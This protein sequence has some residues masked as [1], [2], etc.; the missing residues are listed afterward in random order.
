M[1]LHLPPG[2]HVNS[3]DLADNL[4]YILLIL[5]RIWCSLIGHAIHGEGIPLPSVPN[6][7]SALQ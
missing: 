1:G 3:E 5:I 4:T 6:H 2:E 7:L